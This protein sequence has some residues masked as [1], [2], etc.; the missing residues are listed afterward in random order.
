MATR[1]GQLCCVCSQSMSVETTA[2]RVSIE[3]PQEKMKV[4]LIRSASPLDRHVVW[5]V[6]ILPRLY[7]G[8]ENQGLGYRN[9]MKAIMAQADVEIVKLSDKAK[10][11]TILPKRWVVDWTSA[12]LHRPRRLTKD[13]ECVKRK[14]RTFC[15]SHLYAPCCVGFA[16]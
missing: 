6:S 14:A 4:K 1:P 2:V 16:D 11:F 13:C 10:A 9:A 8:G 7:A 15:C 5:V 3:P 12:W